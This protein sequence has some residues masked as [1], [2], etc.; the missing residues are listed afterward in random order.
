LNGKYS[1]SGFSHVPGGDEY[2]NRSVFSYH[3]YCT[4]IAIDPVPGNSTI[5]S[6]DRIVCDDVEGPALLRSV[7]IDV[8]Q[9]KSNLVNRMTPCLL[10]TTDNSHRLIYP[11]QR[12]WF[13]QK[14]FFCSRNGDRL[15][16]C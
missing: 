12:T 3:Y 6:F 7:Q 2:R 11:G 14:C 13:G 1:G 15:I 8:R 10:Q 5:P 9:L 4:F 16:E